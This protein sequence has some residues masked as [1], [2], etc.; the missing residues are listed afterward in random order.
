MRIE[1]KRQMIHEAKLKN[2]FP[3]LRTRAAATVYKAQGSTHDSVFIDLD[4]IGKCRNDN[5][6]ARMLYVAISRA[7]SQ[8]LLTGDIC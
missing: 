6:L 5:L 1:S 7:R 2:K 3:D 4:D 8:V